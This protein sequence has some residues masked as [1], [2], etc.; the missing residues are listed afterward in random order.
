MSGNKVYFL[1]TNPIIDALQGDRTVLEK[2]TGTTTAYISHI[3]VGELYYG[4]HHSANPKKHIKQIEKAVALL[5]VVGMTVRT[6]K[7]YGKIKS[8]LRKKGKLIPEN[9][10]WIAAMAIEHGF[11]LVTH[12][13]H[14]IGIDGLETE[15]WKG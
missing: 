14:F 12:D 13:R 2:L 7:I 6:P 1:D 4:A 11:T 10:L 9:D 8:E 3:V 5:D 15:D